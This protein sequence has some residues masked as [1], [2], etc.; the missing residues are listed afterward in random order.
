MMLKQLQIALILLVLNIGYG[1]EISVLLSS[2]VYIPAGAQFNKI[3][4]VNLAASGSVEIELAKNVDI[5]IG[6]RYHNAHGTTSFTGETSKLNIYLWNI[7]GRYRFH[8]EK[9]IPNIGIGFGSNLCKEINSIGELTTASFGILIDGG[10]RTELKEGLYLDTKMSYLFSRAKAEN[11]WVD[12]GG[13]G[14]TV[15]VVMIFSTNLL[16]DVK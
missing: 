10:A 14:L 8:H 16:S 11:G 4:G 12:L 6:L 3:Y 2:T 13:L 5:G 15:G 1:Q 9:Y 7:M